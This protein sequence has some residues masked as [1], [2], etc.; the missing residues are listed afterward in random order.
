VPRSLLCVDVSPDG[1]TIAAG[2]ELKSDDAHIIYWDPR[3]PAAPLL[4]HTSTH[5][6]DITALHYLR[7]SSTVPTLLS[8][9]SD[10]LISISNA[11]EEDEDE[12][13]LNV[14][15][16]GCSIAQA[17]WI[18]HPG[19]PAHVWAASD[20]E[21]FSIWSDKLDAENDF[22][23]R[24]LSIRAIDRWTTDYLIGCH[25]S[26]V[27][28]L[29]LFVGSNT[30]DIGLLSNPSYN[31]RDSS[32]HL[33]KQFLGSHKGVVRSVFWDEHN[34]VL[35]TGGEDSQLSAW[36]CAPFSL[37]RDLDAKN[38]MPSKRDLD[39]DIEMDDSPNSSKRL[40]RS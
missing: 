19:A 33:E 23:S 18:A 40:R 15:N 12:A 39:M 22:D 16:W 7:S 36:P 21:T 31:S 3:F 17:G 1:S 27:N 14:S 30:G 2:T 13:V 29:S 38:L 26:D 35:L 11:E 9:S 20:M 28:E 5:S 37:S 10:G 4:A 25:S 8:V 32:W 34:N 24:K 6:D